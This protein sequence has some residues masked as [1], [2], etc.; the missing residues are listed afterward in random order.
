MLPSVLKKQL[1]P[2]KPSSDVRQPSSEEHWDALKSSDASQM[3]GEQLASTH[4]PLAG[5][6]PLKT[7]DNSNA[8][9]P[10]VYQLAAL[11]EDTSDLSNPI[12]QRVK[13]L[14]LEFVLQWLMAGTSPSKASTSGK[15]PQT[16]INGVELM[17]RMLMSSRDNVN[18]LLEILKQGFVDESF[19]N[20]H[21]LKNLISVYNKWMTVCVC[22]CV[23]VCIC[24]CVCFVVFMCV[25]LFVCLCVCMSVCVCFIH[26]L[27]LVNY[28]LTF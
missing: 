21:V 5:G 11:I 17:K 14:I 1:A 26:I 20:D 16:N 27:V 25:Y 2:D 23:C 28:P 8:Q 19:S 10:V 22:V 18:L 12:Y 24:I 13:Q 6:E 4:S 3:A 7:Q 15:G 9:Y